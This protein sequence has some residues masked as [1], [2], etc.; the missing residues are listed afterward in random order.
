MVATL[1]KVETR[2]YEQMQD[3]QG[4]LQ[5]AKEGTE[6]HAKAKEV[7]KE[8]LGL[9]ERF[10]LDVLPWG[11]AGRLLMSGDVEEVLPLDGAKLLEEAKP[12]GPDGRYHLD[13]AKLTA[14]HDG[15]VQPALKGGPFALVLL[16]GAYDL[17]ESV[18]RHDGAP[19]EYL[20]V[21]TERYREFAGEE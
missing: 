19:C 18:R 1:K 12:I 14:R 8:V 7:A 13:P 3:I 20:R 9:L 17:S 6:R 15:Q 16:G 2:L 5:E 4:V 10:Q 11:T 21:T